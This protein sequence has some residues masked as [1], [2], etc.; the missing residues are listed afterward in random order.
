MKKID[1]TRTIAIK[2]NDY[3][4]IYQPSISLIFINS[5]S[6]LLLIIITTM[7]DSEESETE[8]EGYPRW[9]RFCWSVK[10]FGW[11]TN[12]ILA[13][14]KKNIEKVIFNIGY[15]M[16]QA[17]N[18]ADWTMSDAR[19]CVRDN[20]EQG[21]KLKIHAYTQKQRD[22]HRLHLTTNRLNQLKLSL[23]INDSQV[24]MMKI[25]ES[26]AF[27]LE[28]WSDKDSVGSRMKIVKK[29]EKSLAN[30]RELLD[31]TDLTME[32][33]QRETEKTE[34]AVDIG[35]PIEIT[36][37][38]MFQKLQKEEETAKDLMVQQMPRVPKRK[39]FVKKSVSVS[40]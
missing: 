13:Q 21:A 22:I 8:D 33:H 17:T 29:M 14:E 35:Q 32:Q 9:R 36:V 6:L 10:Y 23:T 28:K 4:F 15:D 18:E 38:S 2:S 25:S 5:L 16:K 37:N 3:I 20:D 19:K 24:H 34:L 39:P 12:D 31:E 27:A 1:G 11:S 30:N 26:M 40:H 7:S